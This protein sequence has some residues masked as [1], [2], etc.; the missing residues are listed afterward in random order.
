MG[1][2]DAADG[3][4]VKGRYPTLN[5][6][7]SD[8][9]IE[10]LSTRDGDSKTDGLP[11]AAAE[12]R[13][14]HSDVYKEGEIRTWIAKQ[15][16][17]KWQQNYFYADLKQ[18]VGAAYDLANKSECTRKQ[19]EEFF[20]EKGAKCGVILQHKVYSKPPNAQGK[21]FTDSVTSFIAE[22]MDAFGKMLDDAGE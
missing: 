3:V 7:E 15:K 14:I 12:V 4:K 10:V 2:Y 22:D 6:Q 19:L 20:G 13:I 8:S 1:R 21:V 11:Y 5:E 18:F 16:V 17:G 9:V